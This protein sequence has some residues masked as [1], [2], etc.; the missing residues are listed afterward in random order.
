[1][2]DEPIRVLVVDDTV[3]YRRA[4]SDLL[5]GIAGIEVVGTAANGNIALQKCE[6]LRPQLLTLDF[7]MPE[8]DGL[9]VHPTAPLELYDRESD[10]DESTDVVAA[11]P[12]IVPEISEIMRMARGEPELFPLAGVQAG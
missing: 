3:V 4:V 6:Q 9:G 1:V 8:L 10:I 5:A 12:T 7:E 11:Y 2:N